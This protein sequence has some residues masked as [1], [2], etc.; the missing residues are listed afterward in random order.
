VQDVV[1]TAAAYA[2]PDAEQELALPVVAAVQGYSWVA[3]PDL[4]WA[5]ALV[6]V[7]KVVSLALVQLQEQLPG[8]CL[9]R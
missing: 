7:T 2:V 1:L 8:G 6:Q 4:S 5:P 9:A 3:A